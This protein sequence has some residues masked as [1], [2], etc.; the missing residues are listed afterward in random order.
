MPCDEAAS[1]WSWAAAGSGGEDG[2]AREALCDDRFG[3]EDWEL[4]CRRCEGEDIFAE[5][6]DVVLCCVRSWVLVVDV[7]IGGCD[8]E[9]VEGKC[10]RET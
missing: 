1:F 10:Q 9:R 7:R 2:G 5:M 8:I 3:V 4:R 6:V